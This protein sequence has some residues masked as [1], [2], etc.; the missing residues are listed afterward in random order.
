ML[1]AEVHVLPA[2]CDHASSMLQQA[3]E[4]VWA[5]VERFLQVDARKLGKEPQLYASIQE[6]ISPDVCLAS[7]AVS[8]VSHIIAK[9]T[10]PPVAIS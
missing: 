4:D 10:C 6:A 5:R 2:F 1:Y 9:H 7:L 8:S 3:M